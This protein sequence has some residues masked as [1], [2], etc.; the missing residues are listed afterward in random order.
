M[1]KLSLFKRAVAATLTLTPVMVS[2]KVA[3]RAISAT[4]TLTGAMTFLKTFKQ[5]VSASLV[6]T[7]TVAFVK[8]APRA[9]AASLVLTPAMFLAKLRNFNVGLTLTPDMTK[10]NIILGND[11]VLGVTLNLTPTVKKFMTRTISTGLTLSPA[12]VKKM[13]KTYALGLPLTVAVVKNIPKTFSQALSLSAVQTRHGVQYRA[14]SVSLGLTVTCAAEK[15]APRSFPIALILTPTLAAAPHRD[16]QM[17]TAI[18]FILTQ[19][20]DRDL[21]VDFEADLPLVAEMT[22]VNEGMGL[23]LAATVNLNPEIHI[24]KLD[25]PNLLLGGMLATAN[26]L[27]VNL[28][29]GTLTGASLGKAHLESIDE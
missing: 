1:T 3:P 29:S 26:L 27:N 7:P 28:K 6:L 22:K 11:K 16:R 9:F 8:K 19:A 2:K 15:K 13:A 12:F 18:V 17:D 10:Q 4:L 5:A 25:Y 24:N 14:F 23:T 20:A 21:A